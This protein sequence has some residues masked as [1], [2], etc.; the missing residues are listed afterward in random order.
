[1]IYGRSVTR[2]LACTV[3]LLLGLA[4]AHSLPAAAASGDAPALTRLARQLQDSPMPMRSDFA[5]L[6]LTQMA[7]FYTEEAE[8]ARL[9]TR[10]TPRA[11]DAVQWAASVDAY[12]GRIASLAASIG[13][14]SAINISVGISN[15]VHVYVDG[16]PVILSAAIS[17]QQAAYEARVLERYCTL[18]I[19]EDLLQDVDYGEPALSAEYVT[20]DPGIAYWSFSQY[21]GPVCM[22]NDGLEFQFQQLSDLAVKRA[23]C[24][25]V[26]A[27]LSEL[28][29]A[30]AREQQRGMS[31]NWKVLVIHPAPPGTENRV[32]I[33][34]RDEIRLMLPTLAGSP[35]LVKIV[36]P[37]L[38]ARVRGD[39]FQL[40]VL[41]AEYMMGL[42]EPAEPETG[43]Q[44]YPAF[45]IEYE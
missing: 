10:S 30:L 29:S 3:L 38:T 23:V 4:S 28:A 35:Q 27:E 36:R 33:T 20:T 40:V 19:C 17:N 45:T 42:R 25:R 16:Q 14:E 1:M 43:T 5:W 44:R 31:I 18:Y 21:T 7:A 13:S 15:E 12:A 41:N 39:S 11:R 26:V 34:L 6:A 22:T 24:S 9:E 8:R 2:C 37:W 32:R